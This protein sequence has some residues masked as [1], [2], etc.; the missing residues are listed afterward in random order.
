MTEDKFAIGYSGI[1]YKTSGV[2]A[3][4][5]R[6]QGGRRLRRR[7][8]RR[9]C[10]SGKYP[11]ARFLYVYVNKAPNKPLDPLVREF[12]KYVLSQ[13]GQEI[14]VKDGYIPLPA[15]IVRKSWRSSSRTALVVRRGP[16]ALRAP[17]FTSL[18]STS[19]RSAASAWR[20]STPKR[21]CVVDRAGPLGGLRRRHRHHRE[22]PGHPGLHPGRG[23]AADPGAK[24]E[25]V[26][27][28][29]ARRR[30]P[31]RA[32]LVGRA[33][34][35]RRRPRR[36]TARCGSSAWGW[37]GG[38]RRRID[39]GARRAA[40]IVR[41]ASGAAGEPTR[42][43][44]RHARR[45]GAARA[46]WPS[47]SRSTGQDRRGHARGSPTGRRWSSTRSGGRSAPSPASVDDEGGAARRRGSSPTARWPWCAAP[48]RRTCSPARSTETLSRFEAAV[49]GAAD[50]HGHRSPTRA[51]PLRRHRR[52]ASCSGGR[53][54]DGRAAASRGVV[55]PARPPVT[56]LT[57]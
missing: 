55:A 48:S 27:R 19:P 35:A 22:H 51:Q 43:R 7:R 25:P 21:R 42:A 46:P 49:P 37:Q 15:K 54:Q 13:Q 20:T 28:V 10:C 31:D 56:A 14:V 1:G 12:L 53:S 30:R 29:A 47:R 9:T 18:D 50:A 3:A 4:A 57:C 11:L 45:P 16:V 26:R 39:P 41:G 38:L 24:V 52:A 40:A 5:A 33:P 17:G 8:A 34:H 32:L 36:P 44:R 6:R 2:Q 23:A